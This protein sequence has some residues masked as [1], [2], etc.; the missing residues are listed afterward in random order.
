LHELLVDEKSTEG[1]EIPMPPSD[2]LVD[3]RLWVPP[4]EL[5]VLDQP[6]QHRHPLFVLR[7]DGEQTAACIHEV[8]QDAR[9][10]LVHLL[11]LA[12]HRDLI[13]AEPIGQLSQLALDRPDIFGVRAALHVD[14]R[15]AQR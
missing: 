2:D 1:G 10:G 4:A 5:E 13:E 15:H 11:D 9:I 12:L 8:L 14:L 7:R 6:A 3:L